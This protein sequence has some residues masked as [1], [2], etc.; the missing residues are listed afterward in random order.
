VRAVAG[1]VFADVDE[2]AGEQP[3]TSTPH[4]IN[5]DTIVNQRYLIKITPCGYSC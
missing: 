4:R 1:G 5:S 2:V 3:A